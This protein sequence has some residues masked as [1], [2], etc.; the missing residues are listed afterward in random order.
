MIVIEVF[1]PARALDPAQQQRLGKRLIDALMGTE[2]AHAEA[3]M[4]SA[5]A[6]TQ[7]LI[8]EPAAWITGDRRP[9][10]PRIRPATVA[11]RFPLRALVA[12]GGDALGPLKQALGT[13]G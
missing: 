12:V 2:D 5:R 9:V 4:D 6:P 8:H 7:V 11:A 1:V 13:T 10:A 3:V